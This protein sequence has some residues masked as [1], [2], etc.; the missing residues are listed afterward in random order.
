MTTMTSKLLAAIISQMATNPRGLHGLSHW[1]RVHD[2]GLRLAAET[3]ADRRVVELFALLHDSRRLTDRA[4]PDHGPRGAALAEQYHRDG[5]LLL[6]DAPLRLLLTACRLHTAAR[7]HDDVT[8]RTCFDAD[9]LDL[10]RAGKTVD[11]AFLCTD[12]GRDPAC[13]AWAS[14]RSREG[15]VPDNIIGQTLRA[16][17]AAAP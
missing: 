16:L 4:D 15:I 5:L 2:N 7:T 12:A 13:I 9:R 6:D 8:V 3:G 11:P 14:E 10:A 1:A 17:A